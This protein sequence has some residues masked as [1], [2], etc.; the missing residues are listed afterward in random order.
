MAEQAADR[1]TELAADRTV[2]AI[3]RTYATWVRLGLAAL[4]SGAGA[5]KLL[6]G[7]L[8]GWSVRSIGAALVLF[9]LFAF[10]AAVWRDLHPGTKQTTSDTPRI[11]PLVLVG[12]NAALSVVAFVALISIWSASLSG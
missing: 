2:L 12:A 1:R 9:S 11:P 5:P 10:A 4:A 3:E 7:S 6:A 8:P